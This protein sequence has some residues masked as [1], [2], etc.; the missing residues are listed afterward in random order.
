MIRSLN[1]FRQ[2]Q[3]VN[4][5]ANLLRDKDV[6]IVDKMIT[7]VKR[8]GAR[9]ARRLV[10]VICFLAPLTV[11]AQLSTI[12]DEV[13]VSD[14]SESE[15]SVAFRV[16]LR[17]VLLNNSGDKTL[18]NRDDIRAGLANAQDFVEEVRYRTPEAGKVI[19]R[20][21]SVTD[22]VRKSGRA[23]QL[24][25]VTF[26]RARVLELIDSK[27]ASRS[28]AAAQS[29]DAPFAN[30]RD[31][32]IWV[33]IDDNGN[34]VLVD[35][36]TGVNIVRRSSE[37]A[38]GLGLSVTFPIV[39]PTDLAT[40]SAADIRVNN[41]AKIIQAS[42]RYGKNVVLIGDLSR[43]RTG[44]W[45]GRWV[46]LTLTGENEESTVNSTSLDAALQAGLGWLKSPAGAGPSD[47]Y[48]AGNTRGPTISEALI[49]VS[50]VSSLA[51]YADVLKFIS[52][53]DTVNLASVKE[54]SVDGIVFTVSPRG[55]VRDV[56]TAV[57]GI[58][59]LRQTGTPSAAARSSL[60]NS[61]EL[62]LDYLR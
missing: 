53:I 54:V 37:I 14:R 10:F 55:S 16:A 35:R 39:D 45:T 19:G 41:L 48:V 5:T 22:S 52:G 31:A 13:A 3:P 58:D 8:G 42:Q 32:L 36:A 44:G 29:V 27:S 6:K 57:A 34:D 30:V 20:E 26:N 12:S 11:L 28:E 40:V 38:G 51:S 1:G 15:Q 25:T 43:Q 33:L 4:C 59:W 17:R 2:C 61:I 24:M 21:I 56:A 23:T 18:L 9:S 62:A 7:M 50:S 49:W 46:R 60:S 47:S